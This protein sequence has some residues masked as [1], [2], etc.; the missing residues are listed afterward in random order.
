MALSSFKPPRLTYFKG[1]LLIFM[2]TSREYFS[3]GLSTRLS[4][5]K[6]DPSM[7]ILFP[8]SLDSTRPFSNRITS[9]LFFSILFLLAVLFLGPLLGCKYLNLKDLLRKVYHSSHLVYY[10][11]MVVLCN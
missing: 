7:I 1:L 3:P 5:I 11:L 9:A 4:P 2:S 8:F 6:T 10:M